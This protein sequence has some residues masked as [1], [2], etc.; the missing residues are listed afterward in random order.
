MTRKPPE[1]PNIEDATLRAC[2]APLMDAMHDG[3]TSPP[4]PPV[5]AGVP[6][7]RPNVPAHAA[8]GPAAEAT[9]GS[10]AESNDNPDPSVEPCAAGCPSGMPKSLAEWR[11]LSDDDFGAFRTI[12]LFLAMTDAELET[13]A[14]E[15]P[16]QISGTL[17]RIGR[18]RRRMLAQ[19]DTVTTAMALL[20][21]ALAR[22]G[23]TGPLPPRNA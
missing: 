16:K 3:G 18:I 2:L 19:Y 7:D 20:E 5:V 8:P 11:S 13:A 17:A 23:G 6:A 14:A 12:E 15:F 22:S 4:A 1:L 9:V 21:R 10:P